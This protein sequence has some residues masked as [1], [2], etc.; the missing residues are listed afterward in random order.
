MWRLGVG[1]INGEMLMRSTS[2]GIEW[3]VAYE[4]EVHRRSP[5]LIYTFGNHQRIDGV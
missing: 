5:V 4:S 3:A 1:H 2:G